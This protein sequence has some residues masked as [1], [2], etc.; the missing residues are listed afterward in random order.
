MSLHLK[1]RTPTK[2]PLE[3]DGLLPEVV[4]EKSLS[5]IERLP[6]F[7]GNRQLPVGEFFSVSG[8]PGD[9]RMEFD[10][11]LTGV[12]WIGAKMTAGEIHVSASAGRHVG[13]EMSGG[14]IHVA[15]DA[16]DW[17]G[18]EMHGGLIHVRG[19]AGHLVGAAYRGSVR[20]MTGG[21]I[22]VGGNAGDEVAQTMRRGLIALG[23]SLGDVAGANMIAGTLLVF[24]RGGLRAGA[25]M[26]RGTVA[27]F[28]EPPTLLPTFKLAGRCR[29]LF[30]RIYLRQLQRLGLPRAEPLLDD[31]YLLYHGDLLAGGLGEVLVRLPRAAA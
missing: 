17:L 30:L 23:G 2:V 26:S 29:P 16:G 22:L 6:L 31:D 20:G 7:H 13:S 19:D 1:Y 21:T 12:H 28:G 9:M 24:G 25:G 27:F 8:D 14:A 3:I 18:G 11:D 15:G 5:E 4:R 10:G